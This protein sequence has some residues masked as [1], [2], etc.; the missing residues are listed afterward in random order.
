MKRV[1]WVR[2]AA[3][4]SAAVVALV[5]GASSF[6]HI[7]DV[8]VKYGEHPAVAYSLPFAIDGL[9]IVATTATIEAKRNSRSIH[10]SVR[11]AFAFGILASLGANI[12]S[13]DPSTGARVVAAI[14]A[15]ALL[16]AIEV[17][18][19]SGKPLGDVPAEQP[20]PIAS[21]DQPEEPKPVEPVR[22]TVRR[23]PAAETR[24]L[25]AVMQAKEPALTREQMADRL[26]ISVR[27]LRTVMAAA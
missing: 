15:V 12:A 9:L 24:R 25:V 6:R 19:R 23:R 4:G 8:A 5:A 16:I 7:A 22:P 11:L 18:T 2:V 3:R 14:P 1:D 13:A 20:T 17:L 21:E 26:G 27:R 10:W